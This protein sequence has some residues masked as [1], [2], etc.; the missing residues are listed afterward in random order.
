M[1]VTLGTM[2]LGAFGK[3]DGGNMAAVL[4]SCVAAYNWA[5]VKAAQKETQG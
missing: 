2:A 5:N 1:I 3:M 4:L